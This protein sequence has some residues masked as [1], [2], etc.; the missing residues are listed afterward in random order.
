MIIQINLKHS[1]RINYTMCASG[2]KGTTVST[3]GKMLIA[4]GR[5]YEIP[6]NTNDSLDDHNVFKPVGKLS[7]NMNVHNIRDGVAIVTCVIHNTII[8]HEQELGNF[9]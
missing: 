1:S 4:M 2:E 9:I 3:N 8:E 7:E 6:I 5:V